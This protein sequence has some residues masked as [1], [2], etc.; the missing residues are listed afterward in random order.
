MGRTETTATRDARFVRGSQA[1][2]GKPAGP[3]D[4][5]PPG[6]TGYELSFDDEG[7]VGPGGMD[8]A[9][10]QCEGGRKALGGGFRLFSSA[11]GIRVLASYPES[12][13]QGADSWIVSFANDSQ[14]PPEFTAYAVCA[15]VEP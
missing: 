14:S 5:G 12:E 4:P 1:R 7:E 15:F 2:R 8:G 9:Q 10:A 6:I 3:G 13:E 11:S